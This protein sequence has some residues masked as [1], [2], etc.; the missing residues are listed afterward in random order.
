MGKAAEEGGDT[1]PAVWLPSVRTGSG[2][3]TFTERLAEAL[4]RQGYRA[5]IVWLPLRTEFAPWSV[6]IP[7]RPAWAN[8]LHVNSWLS[9]RFV[10]SHLPVV[11][12]VHLCVHDSSFAGYRSGMQALYHRCWIRRQ[13][14]RMLR[15]ATVV[16]AV[17]S[18]TALQTR[19]AFPG[20][21][22]TVVHNG[23]QANAAWYAPRPPRQGGP[24]RLLY[25]GNWSLR[26]G[27][28][29]LDPL[30]RMLGDGFELLYTP[31]RD[32]NTGG[33]PVPSNARSLGRLAGAEA[34]AQAYRLAD[35]LIFPSRMEGL[36]LV[37]IEAMACG[38]PVVASDASSVTDV[39]RHGETGFLTPAEDLAALATAIVSL[40]DDPVRWAAMS[41]A[42]RRR[43][44]DEFSEA[45][46]LEG[47]LAAY[48]QAL[49]CVPAQGA[50]TVRGVRRRSV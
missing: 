10:P 3:D 45:R 14:S 38:L 40:R 12:T 2:T 22:P 4:T 5:E 24:F 19:R 36:P 47:Y 7:P 23:L 30:L 25:C 49:E 29:L 42:A 16:T 17:S 9:T 27:V 6:P 28:D 32:G 18:Q 33:F 11:A 48:R 15:R 50:R 46:M 21:E 39:V 1:L 8:V 26:K 35:V 43:Q 31:G 20:V 41:D 37:P 13:E 44:A 34:L